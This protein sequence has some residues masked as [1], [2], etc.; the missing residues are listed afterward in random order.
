VAVWPDASGN[1]NDATQ[2]TAALQPTFVGGG[3]PGAKPAVV[4]DGESTFLENTA[5]NLPAGSSVFAVFMDTGSTTDCC[6]GIFYSEGGCNG[7]GTHT[8]TDPNGNP[9]VVTMI[10]W[11]GSG[12]GGSHY[13]LNEPVFVSVVYNS[14]QSTS[15]VNGCLDSAEGAAQAAGTGFMVGS[16]NNQDA[17]FF[18]G[19]LAELIVYPSGLVDADRQSVEQYLS[20]K[21]GIAPTKNCAAYPQPNCTTSQ[22]TQVLLN[23][24]T[25]FVAAMTAAGYPT[26]RYESAHALL[27]AR[28]VQSWTDRCNMINNGTITPLP[29]LASEQAANALYTSNSAN[30][31]NGLLSVLAGYASSSDPDQQK[32]FAIYQRIFG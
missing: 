14:S 9:S 13:I 16:R 22:S 26:A 11:S 2:A 23:N 30:L 7:L 6:S 8:A 20:L 29:T 27:F 4:F 10:D 15:Y 25:A 24:F 3:F 17:R 5:M 31:G 28:T 18:K 19:A 12:D 1:K 21:W 32:I